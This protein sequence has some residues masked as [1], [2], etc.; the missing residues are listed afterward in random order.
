MPRGEQQTILAVPLV[1]FWLY[2]SL[3]AHALKNP[4][5]L[6][7]VA[8]PLIIIFRV[9]YRLWEKGKRSSNKVETQKTS[10]I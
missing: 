7:R 3:P 5:K 8:H 6:K 4:I 2:S 9:H 1:F 10:S